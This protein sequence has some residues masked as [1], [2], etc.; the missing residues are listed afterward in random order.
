MTL[1]F[2]SVRRLRR[3]P[4]AAAASIVLLCAAG[5]AAAGQSG[6]VELVTSFVRDYVS[7]DHAGGTVT[8]GILRGTTTV[9]GSSGGP[10]ALGESNLVVCLVYATK[11][12]AGMDLEAPCTNTDASGDTWFWRARR[13]AGDTEAGGGGEGLRELL[14]GTGKYAGVS[15]T[16]TYS[17]RYLAENRSVSVASCEWRTP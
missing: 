12:D 15:G 17:T 5:T 16:C 11:T 2:T 13:T 10:F 3:V 9:T 6:T 8:G 4:V 1:S 14:G 7:F